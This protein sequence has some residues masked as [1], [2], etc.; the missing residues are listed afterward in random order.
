MQAVLDALA[1]ARAG[2]PNRYELPYPRARAQ[3][4]AERQPWLDDG[5][6]CAQAERT[7]EADGRTVALRAYRP[8]GASDACLLVYLHGGGWCVGSPQTHDNIVRRLAD[9][10][11]CEAW[12]VDYALAPEAPHPAG[13]LDC[14]AVVCAAA[15]AR[16]GARL[17][18][19]G[20]SAGAHLA[21]MTALSLRDGGGPRPDALLLFYGVYTDALDDA[22]MAAYGDGRFGLSKA[23]HLRYLDACFGPGRAGA[24]DA[25]ADG[26]GAQAA[27]RGTPPAFPLDPRIDLAG[28]PDT[29]LTVAELDIL[30][31]Q[32]HALAA[33]LRSAGVTV[34]V[35]DV[36]GVIH[37]FLS[38]GRRLPQ[39]RAALADAAAW[40]RA[41]R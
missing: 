12:S 19:A 16:P 4:L 41:R 29:R 32:S 2:L 8:T 11:G 23:A 33:A 14:V 15:G 31:D 1:A 7:L 24:D 22:S 13:L 35:D 39:A 38:Y 27:S 26:A 10:I 40:I 30:H 21:L 28:L 34:Q 9:G 37:G 3:L 20:D 36:P 17:V 18:V 5:P 25:G 6:A